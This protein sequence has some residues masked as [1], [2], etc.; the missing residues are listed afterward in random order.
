MD[1]YCDMKLECKKIVGL[2]SGLIRIDADMILI[3]H[4]DIINDTFDLDFIMP[5]PVPDQTS[6]EQFLVCKRKEQLQQ[7]FLG[8]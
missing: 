3:E 5:P 2:F 1:Y 6:F 7:K 4:P 8:K